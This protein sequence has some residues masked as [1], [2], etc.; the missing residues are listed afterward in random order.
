MKIKKD[1]AFYYIMCLLTIL[2]TV[3]L[4]SR[5]SMAQTNWKEN[6]LH[7]VNS[8]SKSDGGYGWIDQ[9]DSHLTPTF[10]VIGILKDIDHLPR[11]AR[12]KELVTFVKTHHPQFGP[13]AIPA[14]L[15]KQQHH[16]LYLGEQWRRTEAGTSGS[17][18]RDLVYQQIQAIHWLGGNA[19]EFDTLV[20][21]WESQA[22]N[23][24]NYEKHGYP[25]LYQEMMTPVCRDLLGL[26]FSD[27]DKT[28]AYLESRKRSNGSFNNAPA[29]DGGD[30][31]MLNTYWSLKALHILG[32]DEKPKEET[33][34]W[35]QSCQLKNG[36]FTHQPRLNSSSGQAHPEIGAND[37]VAY[38]WA[39]VKSLQL[40]SANPKD[41]NACINY[42]L[43]LRNA[44]GG[45]GNRPGLPSTPM[46]TF[47]AIDAL[48]TMNAF[49]DLDKS[50]LKKPTEKK[51]D[52]S[53]LKIYS[54]QFEAPG[55]GSP[56]EA[57][58]LAD[59]LHIQLW[60][61]K[62][63]PEGWIATAQKM[64]DEK[65]IPVTFFVADE[66][67]GKW[68][69]V[70][71]MGSFGHILDFM[72]PADAKLPPIGNDPTWQEYH[73]NYVSPLL[74]MGGALILQISNNEPLA[75]LIL[76][77]SIRNGGYAAISTIHF[78]QN[79]LFWVPYLYQYRYQ[80]PFVSLQDAHG[81]EAWWWTDELTG[82][83]TLF[84]A[85]EPTYAAMKKALKNNWVVA[86]RHDSL[87]RF[88]TRILGGAKGVKEYM[89]SHESEWKWWG[90][91]SEELCRPWAAI[92]IVHP[93]DSFEVARPDKGVN[94]RVRCWWKSSRPL[95]K[96]PMVK[97]EKL[98][99]DNSIIKPEYV[100][101]KSR[102]GKLADAY[103]LYKIP[104]ISLGKHEIKATLI[105]LNDHSERLVSK[106]F[107]VNRNTSV[108]DN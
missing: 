91:D 106:S 50:T 102:R 39:A 80:L 89:L 65:H 32:K 56:A 68:V 73:K 46:S 67:Y 29:T 103:Y 13:L 9:P 97:L 36:G 6:M 94:I 48:K 23:L 61:S 41:V 76:D 107:M 19:S 42:L 71:G 3:S 31:N 4:V 79:F 62:N 74:K 5:Q 51:V 24:A 88:K 58:M 14:L 66:P 90:K 11:P 83:R 12:R 16:A 49:S 105:N 96:N 77:E 78:D 10:A 70:N 2:S 55:V 26:N 25:V 1:K 18:M 28:V 95:L 38:T 82:Y 7:Y 99:L 63:G 86:V 72:A 84:L 30:G 52:F 104:E 92:T 93:A 57:V 43:S 108:A 87:S 17:A 60:G 37:E 59:S 64:A 15:Y 27:A 101:K 44:D 75:R 34:H 81:T 22:G 21:I 98:E 40:L 54:A 100:E 8:L 47:Y 45:F 35:L 20:S 69:H 53:G 33:I 85:K